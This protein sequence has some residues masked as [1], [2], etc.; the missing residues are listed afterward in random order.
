MFSR[1]SYSSFDTTENETAHAVFNFTAAVF[2]PPKE[3]GLWKEIHIL[4]LLPDDVVPSIC[5]TVVIDPDKQKYCHG[6]KR[7]IGPT[8]L[9]NILLTKTPK[10]GLQLSK[11]IYEH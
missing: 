9:I 11:T 8:V 10:L 7:S 6:K 5:S 3:L 2:L 1:K 4:P